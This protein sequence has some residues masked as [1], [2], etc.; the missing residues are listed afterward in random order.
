M[1]APRNSGATERPLPGPSPH[2]APWSPR[3]L[4]GKEVRGGSPDVRGSP[5]AAGARADVPVGA[6][7]LQEA[8]GPPFPSELLPRKEGGPP[9]R[10]SLR[11]SREQTVLCSDRRSPNVPQR[12]DLRPPPQK[13]PASPRQSGS[14]HLQLQEGDLR[15]SGVAAGYP[16]YKRDNATAPK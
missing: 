5:A 16:D 14:R 1:R 15:V 7:R 13:P 3:R 11:K 12:H 8:P 6:Q 4:S 2:P 10:S 9:N